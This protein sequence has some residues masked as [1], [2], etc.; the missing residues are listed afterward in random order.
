VLDPDGKACAAF[1]V[2]FD[3]D[4]PDFPVFEP[5]TIVIGKDGKAI[6]EHHGKLPGDR[7]KPEAVLEILRPGTLKVTETAP[8]PVPASTA[9]PAG[10][11]S[12]ARRAATTGAATSRGECSA[13]PG[14][15]DTSRRTA[16]QATW[17]WWTPQRGRASRQRPGRRRYPGSHSLPHPAAAY[18]I[19]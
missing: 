10:T 14:T 19:W 6:F 7:P 17:S 9:A 1:R 2:P 5:A 3:K 16:G 15:G 12:T 13:L 11:C 18:R 8:A 4:S